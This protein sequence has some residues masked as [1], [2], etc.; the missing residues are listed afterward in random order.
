SSGRAAGVGDENVY[1]SK[2][3][4]GGFAECNDVFGFRNISDD[5][6]NVSARRP[7][8]GGG[9]A[10]VLL[11]ACAHHDARSV[12]GKLFGYGAADSFAARG[13]ERDFA[14]DSEIHRYRLR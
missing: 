12:R 9:A 13:D 10:Q 1:A 2:L 11:A 6:Q 3:F 5:V 4:L 8:L 14:I 7:Q